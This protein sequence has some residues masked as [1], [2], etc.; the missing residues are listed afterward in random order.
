MT[1]EQRFCQLTEHHGISYLFHITHR[2]NLESIALSGLKPH[3]QAHADHDPVDVSD[4]NVNQLRSRRDPVHGRSLHEYVP[5][6]FRARNPMLYRRSNVQ[7]ELVILY[8]NKFVMLFPGTVFTDGNAASRSTRFF[9]D[10]ENLDQLDWE[11]L[12][13]EYWSDFVD[14]RR[15]RCAEVLVPRVLPLALV[16]RIVVQNQDSLAMARMATRL[17]DIGVRPDWFFFGV[18]KC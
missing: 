14:G 15:K 2:S 17:R 4:P 11:C 3:N 7:E 16:S 13:A 12:R 6:Y 9:D 10:L 1:S 8:V 5:L 18:L